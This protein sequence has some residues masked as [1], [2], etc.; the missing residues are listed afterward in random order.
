MPEV[1][2]IWQFKVLG[3]GSMCWEV[4]NLA[5]NKEIITA[6]TRQATESHWTDLLVSKPSAINQSMDLRIFSVVGDVR[7]SDR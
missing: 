2:L 1:N 5:K 4:A 6:G 3:G 7:A